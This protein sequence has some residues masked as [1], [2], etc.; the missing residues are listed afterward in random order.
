M[1]G[2]ANSFT[3]LCKHIAHPNSLLSLIGSHFG[4]IDNCL[5]LDYLFLKNMTQA[6]Y[7][8]ALEL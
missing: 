5:L 7:F 4:F 8:L 6:H 2:G 3:I 1:K